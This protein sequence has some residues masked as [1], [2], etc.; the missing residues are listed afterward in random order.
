MPQITDILNA[1]GS[2]KNTAHSYGEMY[3]HLFKRH[4]LTVKNMLEIGIFRGASLNAWAQYFENATIY[5]ADID[6]NI[7]NLLW[8]SPR[9]KPLLMDAT[10]EE[11]IKQNFGDLKF[12]IIIDDGSHMFA[13]QKKSF[14]ILKNYL[15]PGG[16]YVIEDIVEYDKV[17]ADEEFSK[18]FL[19]FDRRLVKNDYCDIMLFYRNAN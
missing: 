19:I 6:P 15:A 1:C 17:L 12:D 18:N 13:H 4:R 14:N 16:Y 3:E 9:I 7:K 2:D 5:G 10:N 8:T 11:L